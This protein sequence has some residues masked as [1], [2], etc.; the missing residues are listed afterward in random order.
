MIR[1]FF[2]IIILDGIMSIVSC[3]G[4]TF[5]TLIVLLISILFTRPDLLGI[6]N[7][8]NSYVP[9]ECWWLIIL[10]VLILTV[11]MMSILIDAFS[12][13]VK[14]IFVCYFIDKEMYQA[15]GSAQ[16]TTDS[17]KPFASSDLKT[18]MKESKDMGSQKIEEYS[19][20][21]EEFSV[22][23]QYEPDDFSFPCEPPTQTYSSAYP[24]AE[25]QTSYPAAK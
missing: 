23:V 13:T 12:F 25:Q 3:L 15:H 8:S 24:T 4:I 20:S 18:H 14:S 10:L 19:Q 16:N 11:I 5:V 21:H 9:S 2:Q 17:Y 22:P 7:N 1:S 6:C